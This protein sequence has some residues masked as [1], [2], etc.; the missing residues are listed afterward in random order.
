MPPP[1]L[2][3]GTPRGMEVLAHLAA[4]LDVRDGGQRRR[5]RRRQ[6][7]RSSSPARCWA[8]RCWRRCGC[9]DS[10]PCSPSPGTPSR[11]RPAASAGR[12]RRVRE[13][14]PEVAAADLVARVV[15]TEPVG[16]G[17]VRRAHLGAGRGRR[18]PRCRRR[19]TG[20]TSVV[21]LA[22]LLGRRARRL[23]RGDQP[24]LAPAPRADRPDR[25][26]DLPGRLHPVR[27]QRG[28]PALGGLRQLEDDP[29]DQHR[30][31][32]ADGHQGDL[33]RH[34]RHARGRPRD[35][36]RDPAAAVAETLDRR[37]TSPT[38]PWAPRCAGSLRPFSVEITPARD[39]E[40]AAA[41]GLLAP[42]TA[43]Y[44]TFLPNAPWDQTVA[45]ARWVATAGMRPVPHLAAR[46]V[47]DRATLRRMLAELTAIG[48]EDVLLI[49]GSMARR[50]ASSTRR[51]RS[52]TPACLE[53]AGIR[54]VGVAGP[55]GGPSRRRRRRA[56]RGRW[57]RRAASPASAASTCTSSRSSRSRPSR[58]WRGSGGSG[59]MGVDAARARRAA[60]ASPRP[61]KLLRFGLSCGVGPSL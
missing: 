39:A 15:S 25:Q 55:P 57:S 19:R 26:P 10:R 7:R 35:Q 28:D 14:T 38:R 12:G 51:H 60:R 4:R 61:A 2:A 56:G 45:A 17:R 3:P 11:P 33:R 58:S 34:R 32:R 18:R 9:R 59:P 23:P 29:R 44:L 37:T 21:E 6:R 54:R 13:F 43:V 31:E 48:V 49:A 36:R 5:D 40:A 47:P 52:S 16:A 53:E 22:E 1:S 50:S 41:V 30:R 46:A 27:H 20:S 42:G 24:G 8:V